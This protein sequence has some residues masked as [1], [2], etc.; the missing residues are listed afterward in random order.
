MRVKTLVANC[1]IICLLGW[2]SSCNDK[3]EEAKL[4]PYNVFECQKDTIGPGHLLKAQT[5]GSDDHLE[6]FYKTLGQK[7]GSPRVTYLNYTIDEWTE[8]FEP[9]KRA[10]DPNIL[11]SPFGLQKI[12][13]YDSVV[14]K[15]AGGTVLQ[16]SLQSE[17]KRAGSRIVDP[18]FTHLELRARPLGK[19]STFSDCNAYDGLKHLLTEVFKDSGLEPSDY[20]ADSAQLALE[21]DYEEKLNLYSERV[22]DLL[23]PSCYPA[24]YHR[25]GT[26]QYRL[27]FC[28]LDDMA[29]SLYAKVRVKD[30]LGPCERFALINIVEDTIVDE[31][32]IHDGPSGY[33]LYLEKDRELREIVLELE[34]GREILFYEE[35][36]LLRKGLPFKPWKRPSEPATEPKK[37]RPDLIS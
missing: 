6:S 10:I 20:Q 22:N 5:I 21:K 11:R 9:E 37:K 7:L 1:I 32:L 24:I 17:P 13:V 12:L 3:K 35:N 8:F 15:D 28:E 14:M 31:V 34:D 36:D 29:D 23:D 30:D 2:I 27:Q 19:D 26:W 18:Y 33:V 4:Y 16:V 25:E